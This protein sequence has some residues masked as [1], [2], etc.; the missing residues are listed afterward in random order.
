MTR[1]TAET[2][3]CLYWVKRGVNWRCLYV[4]RTGDNKH[5]LLS[6]SQVEGPVN[7]LWPDL[8]NSVLYMLKEKLNITGQQNYGAVLGV[9]TAGFTNWGE[10]GTILLS[11][12]S[13]YWRVLFAGS[14][15]RKNPGLESAISRPEYNPTLPP[16]HSTSRQMRWIQRKSKLLQ[17]KSTTVW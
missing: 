17:W 14:R 9:F 12:I 15:E 10:C 4:L 8:D 7:D 13:K 11:H 6:R 3:E 5:V 2:L 1:G 16:V